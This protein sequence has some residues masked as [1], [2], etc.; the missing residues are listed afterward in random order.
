MPYWHGRCP[1]EAIGAGAPTHAILASAA[2]RRPRGKELGKE[3]EMSIGTIGWA[4]VLSTAIVLAGLMGSA[5]VSAGDPEVR[6]RAE[7]IAPPAVGDISGQTDFRNRLSVARRQFSV[8]IEGLDP[9]NEFD[10]MV[11]GIVVGTITVDALGMGDLNFDDS[12][13]PD[14]DD[15]A[16]RFPS[17][18]PALDGGELVQVGTLSATLQ[19]K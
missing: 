15:P 14:V 16:T 13:E 19:A 6:L 12:F 9:G 11:A 1:D 4:K 17:N 18:F 2:S 5:T 10:V 3:L 7:L 8:A